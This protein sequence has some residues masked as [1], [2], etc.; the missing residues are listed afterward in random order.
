MDNTPEIQREDLNMN[1]VSAGQWF[2]S[3]LLGFFIGLAVIIPGFSG[4]T[5]AIIFGLYAPLLYA[6]GNILKDFKRCFL[7]L[8]PIIIGLLIGAIA[9]FFAVQK[10]FKVF[11]FQ[12]ICLFV[13]LMAGA[14]S[15]IFDE[16]KGEK[17][18]FK[19]S[20]LVIIGFVIP[21]TLSLVL[22]F[23][24][25]YGGGVIV[26]SIVGMVLYFALGMGIAITQIVPGL[27][28]T[29]LMV[30]LGVYGSVLATLHI[31]VLQSQPILLLIVGALVLGFVVGMVLF[32]K[33]M[34]GILHRWHSQ[35][36]LVI[37]GLSVGSIISMMCSS[38]MLGAI[39]SWQNGEHNIPLI[40]VFGIL[41]LATGFIVSLLVV[42]FSRRNKRKD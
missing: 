32:S 28:A 39:A 33:I 22:L 8:L 24:T 38:E 26:F 36:F 34:D 17:F 14:C 15:V 11:P 42:K 3:V 30:M 6:V 19:N 40:I 12:M 10:L 37:S 29:A 5:L 21:I 18:N 25:D 13:G 20:M 27:S 4:A 2:K 7:F 16:V 41:L 1:Y 23:A 35:A 9:G 31:H